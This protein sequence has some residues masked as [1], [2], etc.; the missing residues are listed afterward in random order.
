MD[1]ATLA[2]MAVGFVLVIGAACGAEDPPLPDAGAYVATFQ[3]S[4][5]RGR[6]MQLFVGYQRNGS[7][8]DVVVRLD[9]GA[10]VRVEGTFADGQL[11][12]PGV[13]LSSHDEFT[14]GCD[15]G[16]ARLDVLRLRGTGE[17]ISA[18]M[19]GEFHQTYDW[20]MITGGPLDGSYAMREAPAPTF[21]GA[22]RG[23]AP[24]SAWT[25]LPS[26]PVAPTA[27]WFESD[28][29]RV[30]GVLGSTAPSHHID[31]LPA[32]PLPWGAQV[33]AHLAFAR[34]SGE[35]GSTTA[36]ATVDASP[37]AGSFDPE[38]RTLEGLSA[39]GLEMLPDETAGILFGRTGGAYAYA[40]AGWRIA[41]AV[42]VP[43]T[44]APRLRVVHRDADKM[45]PAVLRLVAQDE[46]I[47]LSEERS[48]ELSGAYVEADPFRG[49][50]GPSELVLDLAPL[51]GRHAVFVLDEI[52]TGVCG[53]PYGGGGD[54]GYTLL[55]SIELLP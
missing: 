38:L 33:T 1:K 4:V 5:D 28:G 32:A 44:A 14:D 47:R 24:A 15:F 10:A 49:V 13:E 26:E 50:G 45:R 52:A 40:R 34:A 35:A 19:Q 7:G 48:V 8:A 2:R 41:A 43:D 51:R 17:G 12:V 27:A 39:V 6:A 46:A 18:E 29:A 23:V 53:S 37:P 36:E 31:V 54:Y 16:S 30:E 22:S 20:D 11:V 25:F 9:G 55:E 21:P 42:D 3:P